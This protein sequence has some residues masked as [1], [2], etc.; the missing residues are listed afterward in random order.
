M[1]VGGEGRGITR[2]A[3]S[4]QR[5]GRPGKPLAPVKRA[6]LRGGT[7]GSQRRTRALRARTTKPG[8]FGSSESP[9]TTRAPHERGSPI[10]LS[11]LRSVASGAQMGSYPQRLTRLRSLMARPARRCR[12]ECGPWITARV[13]RQGSHP[14]GP[15]RA[16]RGSGGGRSTAGTR[17]RPGVPGTP[18]STK[19]ERVHVIGVP[20]PWDDWSP[21]REL[22]RS[23]RS[24]RVQSQF[25]R[26]RCSWRMV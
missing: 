2:P 10:L 1:R 3:R 6:A 20:V 9:R 25:W 21:G 18:S 13:P 15:R 8:A 12:A 14:E 19:R 17:A 16:P 23:G 11:S 26:S 24:L 4:A 22:H 7:G 5:A